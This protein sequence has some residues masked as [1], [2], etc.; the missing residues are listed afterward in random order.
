[1]FEIFNLFP[2]NFYFLERFCFSPHSGKAT[3]DFKYTVESV[4]EVPTYNTL[5]MYWDGATQWESVYKTNKVTFPPIIHP[6]TTDV[7]LH[8]HTLG[9]YKL[10]NKHHKC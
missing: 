4:N 8:S 10:R 3:F 9:L 6:I 2:Q 5:L 7:L 1:M